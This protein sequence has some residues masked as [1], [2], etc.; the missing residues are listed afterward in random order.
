M[1]MTG[2]VTVGLPAAVG[3]AAAVITGALTAKGQ[4]AAVKDEIAN[5]NSIA[6]V[7]EF[8]G[9]QM[10]LARIQIRDQ[11]AQNLRS[12]VPIDDLELFRD[13]LPADGKVQLARL[14]HFFEKMHGMISADAVNADL[15]RKTLGQ[16]LSW[17]YVNLLTHF[18]KGSAN[19]EWGPLLTKLE[20]LHLHCPEDDMR[21][22]RAH[23][24]RTIGN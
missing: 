6:L 23:Y 9:E 5:N 14:L 7:D 22:Y 11:L 3:I 21:R 13:K 15:I 20:S 16:K 19:S 2:W 1:D 4:R 8:F 17:W 18:F 24:A 10:H 12:P